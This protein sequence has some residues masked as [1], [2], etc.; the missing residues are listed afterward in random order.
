MKA[1]LKHAEDDR[2]VKAVILK[3]DSPGGGVLASDE[4][5]RAL[6]DFQQQRHNAKPIVASMGN[7]AASGGYY[8]S[9]PCQWIVANDLTITG[10]IGVILHSWN[11]RGLMNKVGL[12]PETYKSGKFKDMLSGE[13]NPDEIPAEE[14]EMVQKLID[15]TYG[16]FKDV[17]AK[18]REWAHAQNKNS[19]E[20]KDQGQE[21]SS[22]WGDYA[23][24]RVLSGNEAYK[25]GFVDQLGNFQ[26]AVK[27]ARKMAGISEAN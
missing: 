24:G 23:D 10:S 3:V 7:L 9:S 27:R 18:G 6:W 1:Q 21:L 16:R 11:Y 2:K 12:R 17:V 13:R 14:R 5:Y 25:L 20:K 4:I 8:V 22:N 19:S 15:D 26:D